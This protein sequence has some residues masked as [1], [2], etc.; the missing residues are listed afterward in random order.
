MK[1][2]AWAINKNPRFNRWFYQY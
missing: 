2:P 1:E